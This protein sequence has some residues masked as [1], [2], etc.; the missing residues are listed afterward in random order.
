MGIMH[1][2]GHIHQIQQKEMAIEKK[3]NDG[4]KERLDTF[5]ASLKAVRSYFKNKNVEL[6]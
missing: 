6:G 2:S 4:E 1:I 5:K 3:Y